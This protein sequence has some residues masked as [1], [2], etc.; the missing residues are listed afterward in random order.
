MEGS[1]SQPLDSKKNYH[2]TSVSSLGFFVAPIKGKFLCSE[3]LTE[4]K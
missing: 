1:C 3:L 4:V 2:V